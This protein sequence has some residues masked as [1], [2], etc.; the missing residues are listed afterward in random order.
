MWLGM[1]YLLEGRILTLRRPEA[2]VERLSYIGIANIAIGIIIAFILLEPYI[3]K[4][5]ITL[6]QMGF[7]NYRKTLASIFVGFIF[8]L[9][10][11]IIQS[12]PSMNPIVIVNAYAQVLSV[13]IAEIVVCWAIVGTVVESY[14]KSYNEY[15]AIAIA[16]VISSIAFGVYHFGHSPPFNT[17]NMVILLTFIG[18]ITGLFY[19]ISRNIYGTITFHNF[20]GIFGVTKSLDEAGKLSTYTE[21]QMP[22]FLTAIMAI[23]ALYFSYRYILKPSGEGC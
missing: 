13:S 19:F 7:G 17:I 5:Y 21:F 3:L 12:P 16:I 6:K 9:I 2:V 23:I 22:L 10:F 11:Y 20:L 15:I 18:L 14:L 1:T 4:K 8:G